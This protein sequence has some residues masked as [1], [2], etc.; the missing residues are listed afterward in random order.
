M[1]LNNE[2][3]EI[4]IEVDETYNINSTNNK[5][6]DYVYNP[7][8]LDNH[9][10]INVFSIHIKS[11]ERVINIALIGGLYSNIDNCAIL[12]NNVL[13][14]LQND[15][16][17]EIDIK[18]GRLLSSKII[19]TYGSNFSIHRIETGYIIHGEINIIKLTF[20]FEIEWTF[21]ARDI[22]ATLYDKPAFKLC[23]NCIK[24]Y[25]FENNY[26]EIDFNGKLIQENIAE[27][28]SLRFWY[29]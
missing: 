12:H 14:V 23:D 24:L 10:F 17:S 28:E 16:I 18:T 5:H 2:I 1:I 6:Y 27:W 4:I 22:F 25:D 8:K 15:I 20:D 9:E 29:V 11:N 26:Y 19:E 13:I 21:S 3:Y 7:H